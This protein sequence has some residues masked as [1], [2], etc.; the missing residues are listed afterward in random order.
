MTLCNTPT[1]REVEIKRAMMDV[2]DEIVAFPFTF[3][4]MGIFGETKV[5]F[6]APNVNFSLLG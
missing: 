6:I 2:T 1:E 3:N 5:L 4:Y